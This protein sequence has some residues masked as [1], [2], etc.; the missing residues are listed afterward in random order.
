[1]NAMSVQEE[2]ATL[3]ATQVTTASVPRRETD[4]GPG[5]MPPEAKQAPI[6][7]VVNKLIA[8]LMVGYLTFMLW[9]AI[10]LGPIATAGFFGWL[11][12]LSLF[13]Y[14]VWRD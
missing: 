3:T 11:T 9:W 12:Y 4:M 13:S 14:L 1:M 2:S 8:A 10:T 5:G 6:V 7:F